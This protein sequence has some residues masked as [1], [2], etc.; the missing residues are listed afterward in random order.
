[1]PGGAKPQ[2]RRVVAAVAVCVAGASACTSSTSPHSVPPTPKAVPG[3]ADLLA[4]AGGVVWAS[5]LRGDTSVIL[6]S[7]DDGRHWRVALSVPTSNHDFGIVASYFLGPEHAWALDE[8]VDGASW[9]YYT[10]DGGRSWQTTGLPESGAAGSP[11]HDQIEFRTPTDGSLLAVGTAYGPTDALS[12][13]AWRTTDGGASWH[14]LPSLPL[15]GLRLAAYGRTA[16]PVFAPPHLTLGADGTG[17]YTSGGCEHGVARPRVWRTE[18]G[19]THWSAVRLPAPAGGW[20]RWNVLGQGGTE[21]GAVSI[22]DTGTSAT[23]LVPVAVGAASLVVERS[24]DAGRSWQLAGEMN[25]RGAPTRTPPAELFDPVDVDRWVVSATGGLVETADGGRTWTFFRAILDDPEQPIS[26]RTLRDGFRAGSDLVAAQRTTDAGR[27]WT[28]LAVRPP[29]TTTAAWADEYPTGT[30]AA[31][32]PRSVVAGG[33][34]GLLVSGD[35]GATWIRRLGPTMPV[36]Q[37]DAVD[38][39]TIFAVTGDELLRSTDSGRTWA[40]I[41]QPETGPVEQVQFSSD[42]TGVA[43][44]NDQLLRTDDGGRDWTPVPPPVGWTLPGTSLAG[45]R[46]G[47]ACFAQGAAWTV[48]QRAG[49]PAVLV[50]VDGGLTWREALAPSAF[51]AARR[52]VDPVQVAGCRGSVGWVL[53]SGAP[54]GMSGTPDGYALLRSAD[55]GRSWVQVLR[56]SHYAP[57]VRVRT[58]AGGVPTGPAGNPIGLTTTGTGGAW[59]TVADAGVGQ[60]A[61]LSTTVAGRHWTITRLPP[62][63]IGNWLATAADRRHAWTLFGGS[64]D[65]WTSFGYATSDAGRH[66]TKRTTFSWPN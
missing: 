55:V 56:T 40:P 66:W 30:I 45:P 64:K 16:C 15:Q 60:P 21:T 58:P 28:A 44:V 41:T 34:A 46:P 25:T 50:S 17:W 8:H 1:M 6:R 37:L 49:R 54:V 13:A 20:G 27:S 52:S 63:A 12:L 14:R 42:R 22:I 33:A 29:R 23:L 43:V 38:S 18:D 32:G 61:V 31:L 39:R 2:L 4:A 47:S 11:T 59:M 24:T 26:F 65:S 10:S 35:G 9:V 62:A 53:V 5:H 7:G 36:E 19:G 48:A 3:A 57:R 51:P